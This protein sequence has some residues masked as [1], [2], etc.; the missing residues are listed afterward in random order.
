MNRDEL[1][2]RPIGGGLRR[3]GGGETPAW[4]FP[5]DPAAGGTWLGMNDRGVVLAL[6][7]HY[8]ADVAHHADAP[9]RGRLIPATLGAL[10]A[11]ASIARLPPLQGTNPFRLVAAD[12][13]GVWSA[14]WDAHTLALASHGRGP[15]LAASSGWSSEQVAAH[16]ATLF[17]ALLRDAEGLDAEVGAVAAQGGLSRVA[18]REFHLRRDWEHG[19][20]GVNM[21]VEIAATRA[22]SEVIVGT[23]RVSLVH[24]EGRFDQ[25]GAGDPLRDLPEP[26]WLVRR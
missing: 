11:E 7:N 2:S 13:S 25:E 4:M 1:R 9:S 5:V 23:E 26:A 16:R 18:H 12:A 21:A 10:G 8:P 15:F 20:M 22:V 17:S 19:A 24:R 14:T 6:L 3:G